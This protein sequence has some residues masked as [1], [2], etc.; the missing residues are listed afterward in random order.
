MKRLR[1]LPKASAPSAPSLFVSLPEPAS[2]FHCPS[3]AFEPGPS[4][5]PITGSAS[6]CHPFYTPLSCTALP[7]CPRKTIQFP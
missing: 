7:S 1:P 5:P 2:L 6:L 3:I 4:T